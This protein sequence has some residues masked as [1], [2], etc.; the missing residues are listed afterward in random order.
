MR[1]PMFRAALLSLV[2]FSSTGCGGGAAS[3]KTTCDCNNSLAAPEKCPGEWG[4]NASGTC[5][6]SCKNLC[7]PNGVSTCRAD[8]ECGTTF[9]TARKACK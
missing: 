8:E 9:C 6:Y 5:E 1:P 3:C 4:C 7:D 2:L